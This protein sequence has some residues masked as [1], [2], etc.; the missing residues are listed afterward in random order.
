MRKDRGLNI[1]QYEKQTRLSNSLLDAQ[2][3]REGQPSLKGFCD[4]V[5]G[6]KLEVAG[7]LID[8]RTSTGSFISRPSRKQSKVLLTGTLTNHVTTFLIPRLLS[9]TL[10]RFYMFTLKYKK[11]KYSRPNCMTQPRRLGTMK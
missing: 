7:S 8:K 11:T 6:L 3:M 1:L 5:L 9:L 4:L 10:L 2:E